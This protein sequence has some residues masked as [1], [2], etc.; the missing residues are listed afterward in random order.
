MWSL[1]CIF[2]ELVM[3]QPLFPGR[4]EIDVLFRMFRLLGTPTDQTWQGAYDLP[5]MKMSFPH[6]KVNDNENLIKQCTALQH[7]PEA[8]DFL[9]QLLHMEPSKRITIKAAL[10][11]PFFRNSGGLNTSLPSI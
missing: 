5:D 2:Y 1:G 7:H 3:G 8:L 11:H 10:E 6:W 4:S 9:A